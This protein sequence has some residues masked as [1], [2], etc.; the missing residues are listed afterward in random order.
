MTREQVDANDAALSHPWID[1]EVQFNDLDFGPDHIEPSNEHCG[2]AWVDHSTPV[3][4]D[5]DVRSWDCLKNHWVGIRKEITLVHKNYLK[6]GSLDPQD[7]SDDY[8][9]C[10]G[11][12]WVRYIYLAALRRSNAGYDTLEVIANTLGNDS[13][14]EDGVGEGQEQIAGST[15]G[16]RKRKAPGGKGGPPSD[17][18]T[19]TRWARH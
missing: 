16:S 15:S 2:E 8:N 5:K 10:G 17:A 6:S 4:W 12:T 1:V 7:T 13:K 14:C 18:L 19:Q 11:N 9:F 3:Y